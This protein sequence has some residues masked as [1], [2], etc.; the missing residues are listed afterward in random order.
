MNTRFTTGSV[1]RFAIGAALYG[2]VTMHAVAA[3]EKPRITYSQFVAQQ[4]HQQ[5]FITVAEIIQQY[6]DEM[7]GTHTGKPVKPIGESHGFILRALQRMPIGQK[8]AASLTKADV[9][10]HCQWRRETVCAATV[11]Q[12]ICFLSGVLKYA[13]SAWGDCQNV[14]DG[15]ISTAKPFLVTNDL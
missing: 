13:G 9:I 14:S 2:S 10:G 6:M 3:V 1:I 5:H 15:C 7:N 8:A 11:N 12:D 4:Q